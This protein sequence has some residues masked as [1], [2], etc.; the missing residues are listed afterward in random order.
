MTKRVWVEFLWSAIVILCA[1]GPARGQQL[2]ISPDVHSQVEFRY[3]GPIGGRTMAVV[4]IPGNPDVYY[5]GAAAGGIFKLT[6]GG[7]HLDSVFEGQ[8]IL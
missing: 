8:S 4:G 5:V 3:I 7:I 1:P 2:Q 6:E